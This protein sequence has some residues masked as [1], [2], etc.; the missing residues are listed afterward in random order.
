M[1]TVVLGHVPALFLLQFP[2]KLGFLTVLNHCVALL[3]AMKLFVS[4]L[5]GKS[6]GLLT[7]DFCNDICLIPLIFN[8][9]TMTALFE[10]FIADC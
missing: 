5:P 4:F 2:L 9:C 8:S 1:V 7:W 6:Q 10:F 3:G